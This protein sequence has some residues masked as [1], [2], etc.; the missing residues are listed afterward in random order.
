MTTEF[1]QTTAP[2][3][4]DED[5]ARLR[6]AVRPYYTESRFVHAM[7]VEEEAAKIGEMLLPEKVPALRAAAILH[8][9]TKK[10]DT[11]KQLQCCAEFGIIVKEPLSPPILHALTG[12]EVALR[13]FPAYTNEEIAGAIRW[14]TTGRWGMTDFEAVICLA[15]YIEP[16]R[17][18]PACQALGDSFHGELFR[19]N[20]MDERFDAFYRALIL[21]FDQTITH[22]VARGVVLD[23]HA[24]MARNYYI[25][26][27]SNPD[28]TPMSGGNRVMRK[29]PL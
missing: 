1:N 23:P 6:E 7:A 25:L 20:T 15:D 14:H 8:D 9:I 16:T 29:K 19:A 11:Q 4:A 17:P 24:V 3:L 18:Y 12:A 28:N 2:L 26:R 22:L 10:Y 27:K 13:D 21:Y 5:L